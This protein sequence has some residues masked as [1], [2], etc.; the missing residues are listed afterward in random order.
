MGN[1]KWKMGNGR[2]QFIPELHPV[3]GCAV[4]LR[5]FARESP[6]RNVDPSF[7]LTVDLDNAE[8]RAILTDSVGRCFRKA[9]LAIVY[10]VS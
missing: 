5:S 8:A 2:M 1:G 6:P 9:G 10:V 7:C 3:A 4:D